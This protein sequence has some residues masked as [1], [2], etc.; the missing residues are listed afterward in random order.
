MPTSQI[1][2][3][4]IARKALKPDTCKKYIEYIFD[5]LPESEAKKIAN[6]FIGN[7][8]RKYDKTNYG[9]TCT[10]Y[11]TATAFWISAMA[12]KKNVT[13]D[14]H[15]GIYLIRE[16]KIDRIFSDHTSI[17]RFVVSEATVEP[18]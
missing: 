2:Y 17:N 12:E 1:K 9:F 6:S 5:D 14:Q 7:L 10:E 16:Q 8:G 18:R 4:I 11:E 3:K 15:N 13:I